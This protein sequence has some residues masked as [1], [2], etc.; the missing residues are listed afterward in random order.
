MQKYSYIIDSCAALCEKHQ[1]R[2]PLLLAEADGI[3][4]F[5]RFDFEQLKGMY[6]VLNNW[7]CIFYKADLAEPQIA[8]IIAH[9]LGHDQLHQDYIEAGREFI[10]HSLF[11]PRSKLEREANFFAAELLLTDREFFDLMEEGAALEWAAQTCGYNP[12]LLLYKAE[13]LR[14]KGYQLSLPFT[15]RAD[16]LAT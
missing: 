14:S 1:S 12:N 13:L 2:D 15:P 11:D 8:E 10:D 9:E 5:P 4:L 6:M 7:R 3:H 16:F